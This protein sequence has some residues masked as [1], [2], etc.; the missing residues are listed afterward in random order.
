MRLKKK[1]PINDILFKNISYY[2][3]LKH[4]I[5]GHTSPLKNKHIK[6]KKTNYN[7]DH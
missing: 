1:K 4:S 3:G 6:S 5:Q 2:S 7:P